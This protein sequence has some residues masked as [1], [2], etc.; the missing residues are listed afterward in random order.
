M[1]IVPLA[2]LPVPYAATHIEAAIRHLQGASSHDNIKL[3]LRRS[4]EDV[5]T[6]P[7][8]RTL[9][10][11]VGTIAGTELA[12]TRASQSAHTGSSCL[13]QTRAYFQVADG[14]ARRYDTPTQV[15]GLL[16]FAR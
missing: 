5:V 9:C 10:V 12:H 2:L 4:S 16:A 1:R 11:L 3:H 15:V 7:V 8:E 13:S 14:P 6:Q